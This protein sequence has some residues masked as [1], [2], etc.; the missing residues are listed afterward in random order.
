MRH[1]KRSRGIAAIAA[2]LAILTEPSARVVAATAGQTPSK[3]P[4]SSTQTP[5]APP[6][7]T[8]APPSAT[9]QS[10]TPPATAST[11]PAPAAATPA[12][13][14][15]GWPRVYPL[16]NDGNVLVY[17]PQ[18]AS[19]DNQKHVVAFSAVSFRDKTTAEKPALGTIRLEADTLVSVTER[20]VS[21]KNLKIAEANF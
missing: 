13:I 17:Q 15:G 12:P 14:D 10:K 19:W 16:A 2:A 21:L 20:L 3:P 4:A 7:T 6:K 1:E 8:P 9:P 11:T 5:P 18:I